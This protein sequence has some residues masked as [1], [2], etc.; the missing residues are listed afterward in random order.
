MEVKDEKK[1]TSTK[2]SNNFVKRVSIRNYY[3]KSF[4]RETQTQVEKFPL[5]KLNGW[6]FKIPV[7]ETEKLISF[8]TGDTAL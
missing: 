2:Q 5:M 6:H 3:Y 4:N 8:W 1:K 7:A